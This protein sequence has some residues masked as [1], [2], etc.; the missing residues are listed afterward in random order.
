MTIA[1]PPNPHPFL[2]PGP[3]KTKARRPKPAAF[4]LP[5]GLSHSKGKE[6]NEEND[7]NDDN[8]G[9]GVPAPRGA[10]WSPETALPP[11]SSRTTPPVLEGGGGT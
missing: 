7:G 4:P 1:L 5:D 11:F 2:V 10:F 3:P 6:D 9:E 8:E